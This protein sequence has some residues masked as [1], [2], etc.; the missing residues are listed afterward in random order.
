ML[1]A[2]SFPDEADM[3][4][5]VAIKWRDVLGKGIRGRSG[6][7]PFFSP[8]LFPFSV[9]F[10][11]SVARGPLHRPVALGARAGRMALQ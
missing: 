2:T 5:S 10:A 7:I 9:G 4:D 1:K 6:V 8:F 11:G 3:Q